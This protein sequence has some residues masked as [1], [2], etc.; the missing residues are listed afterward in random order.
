MRGPRI[1]SKKPPQIKVEVVPVGPMQDRILSIKD[2]CREANI[3]RSTFYR[4][5][6]AGR[7]KVKRLGSAVKIPGEEFLRFKASL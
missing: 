6:A 3:G 2:F 1:M 4:L 5:V 7:I